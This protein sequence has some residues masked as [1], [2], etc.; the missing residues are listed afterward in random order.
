MRLKTS[1][2]SRH[3]AEYAFAA[4]RARSTSKS[5]TA[6][7]R[8]ICIDAVLPPLGDPASAQLKLMDLHMMVSLAGKERTEDEWRRLFRSTGFALE[9][10]VHPDPRRG[11][12]LIEGVRT[13]G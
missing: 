3:C 8:L 13:R 9:R 12:S 2:L 10:I 1:A 6:G 11:A 4:C 5:P 7:G